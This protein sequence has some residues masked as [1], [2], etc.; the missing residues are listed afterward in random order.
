MT[1]AST[2]TTAAAD[3]PLDLDPPPTRAHKRELEELRVKMRMLEGRR[4]ED[5]ERTRVMEAKV[6]EAENFMAARSKLQ[7]KFAELQ[8]ELAMFRRANKELEASRTTHDSREAEL[9]EQLEMATLDREVAEERAEAAAAELAEAQEQLEVLRVEVGVLKEE[10]AMW[11]GGEVP[12]GPRTDLAFVQLEKHNERL[13]DAL[14]RLRDVSSET[15]KMLRTQVSELERDVGAQQ[16][17]REQLE[18]RS[19]QL[20]EAESAIEDLKQQLDSALGAEEMLEQLTERTLNMGER[21]EEMRITIEDLEALKEMNDELE[22]NHIETEKQLEGEIEALGAQVSQERQRVVALA[23]TVS[24]RDGTIAQF[25]E[26][27]AVLQDEI[28]QLRALQDATSEMSDPAARSQALLDLNLKLQ[29]T[30][31]K[32]QARLVDLDLLGIEA[33]QAKEHVRILEAFLPSSFTDADGKSIAAYSG[34][35]RVT[36]KADVLDR[37]ICAKHELPQALSEARDEALVG[38]C[39]LRGQLLHFSNE[40]RQLA[41]IASRVSADDFL[42]LSRIQADVSALESKVDAWIDRTKKDELPERDLAIELKQCVAAVEHLRA[43]HAD[44]ALDEAERQLAAAITFGYDLDN[45]AAAVGFARQAVRAV[46]DELGVEAVG[47]SLDDTVYDPAQRILQQVQRVKQMADQLAAEV[48]TAQSQSKALP[49]ALNAP[50]KMLVGAVS[51]ATD[52]AI[53]LAQKVGEHVA[54]VRDERRPLVLGDVVAFLTEITADVAGAQDIPPWDII[55][56]FVTRLGSDLG[57]FLPQ[58]RGA[59]QDGQLVALPSLAPWTARSDALRAQSASSVDAEHLV[60]SHAER[61][62]QLRR[63]VRARDETLEETNVKFELVQRK[64]EDSRRKIEAM[65]GLE[66]E[67]DK[68]RRQE[69]LLKESL[70]RLQ[71]EYDTLDAEHS[72]LRQATPDRKGHGTRVVSGAVDLTPPGSG[73]AAELQRRVD[74]LTGAINVLRREN[75]LL[76]AQGVLD[77]VGRLSPLRPS[78]P[79]LSPPDSVSSAASSLDTPPP[80]QPRLLWREL[81]RSQ[82][83]TAIVDLTQIKPGGGWRPSRVLPEHQYA[84]MR[85]EKRRLESKIAEQM[86]R[87]TSSNE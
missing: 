14:I 83:S 26:L 39:E 21:I 8:Q 55:G 69:A 87:W 9:Q 51:K 58:V 45:F 19:A 63:D 29:S 35:V 52:V 49:P 84:A 10:H 5:L 57:A 86:R 36:T 48:R 46:V 75:M 22:E 31:A 42:A 38:V 60:A 65:V 34:L 47:A 28:A 4:Q 56:M 77:D 74:S 33:A 27:V 24:E 62:Q 67:L 23:E 32:N 85:Q 73:S 68:A 78:T 81:A 72:R 17:V 18:A 43:I 6:L 25:R 79:P 15:E 76:K 37:M 7:A 50:L 2:P 54:I 30:A 61:I 53:K 20:A 3:F 59:V 1:P 66:G 70:A 80:M 64:W 82:A 44:T 11:A 40:T 12:D 41:A 13:K 71:A 16:G